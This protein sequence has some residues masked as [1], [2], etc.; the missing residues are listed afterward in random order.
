MR[1]LFPYLYPLPYG[2]DTFCRVLPF[3]IRSIHNLSTLKDLLQP[4][5]TCLR[6]DWGLTP[7]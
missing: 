4:L 6:V 2:G 3:F 5:P 1:D 7:I